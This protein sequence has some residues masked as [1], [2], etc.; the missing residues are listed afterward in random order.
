MG[1][2]VVCGLD[3]HRSLLVACL[4]GGGRAPEIAF[5]QTNR[6]ELKR[7]ESWL[8]ARGC[9]VV[10]MEATGVYWKPIYHALEA[11]RRLVVANPQHIKAMKGRKTD[12]ADAAWIARKLEDEDGIRPSFV[13]A[14]AVRE[15]RE[16]V[17]FR[18]NL[19]KAR[20]Q[21]RNEIQ[22]L[23]AGAGVPLKDAINDLFGVSGQEILRQMASGETAWDRLEDMV[24]GK[25]KAKV[26]Q[27]RLALEMSLTE[28]QR[29]EL[30]A[31]LRRHDQVEQELQ[32]VGKELSKRL[33][34]LESVKLRLMMIP[35]IAEEGAS[36][37]LGFFGND[38][39]TFP[40]DGH[41][42]AWIGLSPGDNE[43]AGK[44]HYAG[45]RKGNRFL[46]GKF[47]QFAWAAARTKGCW[48][49]QKY[50]SLSARM[51]KQK[52]IGAIAHKLAVIVYHV[53]KDETEYRDHGETYV[54]GRS[55]A[56][57]LRRA[58]KLIESQGGKVQ[59]SQTEDLQIETHPAERGFTG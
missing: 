25:L 6:R 45:R 10:G 11:G 43:S 2:D 55:K 52:A 21:I 58:I 13:P 34:G 29:W 5:F 50:R 54:R 37:L 27:M 32:R 59:L 20:T 31:Q 56:K 41:F 48:L 14:K 19:V 15:T 47:T 16:L 4:R 1:T 38:L 33:K 23:L 46:Q 24:K 42:S 9:C 17:R 51:P 3:V 53:I 36:L 30:K 40:T 7:L 12:R 57:A 26:E 44:R 28:A 18:E 8:D 39:S 49:Q 35:G 22:K